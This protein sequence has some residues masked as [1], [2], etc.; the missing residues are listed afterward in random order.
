MGAPLLARSLR[1]KKGFSEAE[2]AGPAPLRLPKDGHIYCRKHI[3]KAELPTH[4]L[5]NLPIHYGGHILPRTQIPH[6]HDA[7]PVSRQLSPLARL[8]RILLNRLIL[9]AVHHKPNGPKA[10][11]S[12]SHHAQSFPADTDLSRSHHLLRDR[13]QNFMIHCE[14]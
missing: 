10:P 9:H 1:E 14:V 4:I 7:M 6:L 3:E 2:L 8:L 5:R 11:R 13:L 12:S